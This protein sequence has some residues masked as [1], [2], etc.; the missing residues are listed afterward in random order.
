MPPCVEVQGPCASALASN[1]SVGE[2]SITSESLGAPQA[3]TRLN[4]NR[5]DKGLNIELMWTG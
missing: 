5:E 3:A 1:W 2:G 4:S